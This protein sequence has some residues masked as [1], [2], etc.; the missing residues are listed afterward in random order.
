MIYIISARIILE[1]CEDL[2]SI[3]WDIYKDSANLV[4]CYFIDLY[5]IKV[6]AI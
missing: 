4:Q 1:T 5:F 2:K 6:I 3:M